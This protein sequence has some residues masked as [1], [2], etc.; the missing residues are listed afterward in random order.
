MEDCYDLRNAME[1]LIR[2][3]RLAKYVAS[4]RSPRRRLVFDQGD[5]E[6]RN[7]RSQR[8]SKHERHQDHDEENPV[9]ELSM[10]SQEASREEE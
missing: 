5:E 8:T 9:Q 4:Q 6:R 2:E 7:S 1:Q 3:D 10:S